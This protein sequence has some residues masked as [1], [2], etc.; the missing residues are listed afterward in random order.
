MIVRG[1]VARG[2]GEARRLGYPTANVSH[3]TPGLSPGIFLARVLVG[4]AVH[5]G[6]AVV[7]M[8]TDEASGHPSLE[9]YLL[10]FSGDLYGRT[11]AVAV[12]EKLRDLAAF[13][14]ADALV[15]QIKKDIEDARARFNNMSS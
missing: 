4:T 11:L 7:G 2:K 1:V 6:I 10:D 12:G 5:Q 9:A 3:D 8:W 14:D 15:A 13:P